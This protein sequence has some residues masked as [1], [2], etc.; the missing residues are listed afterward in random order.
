M[1]DS[2]MLRMECFINN[3]C[4]PCENRKKR[5]LDI[6]SY[7]VNG[8]YKPLFLEKGFEYV[9]LDISEGP[10]VDV[11]P[12][13]MYDWEIIED[14]SFDYIVSGQAFEHIEYPWLTINEIKKK[15]KK[16][17]IIC[18]IAPNGLGEHRYPVDCW[19]F[20]GDGMRALARWCGLEVIETSIGGVPDLY[21]SKKFDSTWN[22]ACLVACKSVDTKNKYKDKQMFPVERR[23]D[24]Y[25]DLKL[26]SEFLGKWKCDEERINQLLIEGVVKKNCSFVY[27]IG[28]E[29]LAEALDK[30]LKRQNIKC[31]CI[32][33]DYISENG[34]SIDNKQILYIITTIDVCRVVARRI[35]NRMQHATVLYLDYL[36]QEEIINQYLKV[37]KNQF[38]ECRNIYIYGAGVNAKEIEDVLNKEGIPFSGFVVSD[39]RIGDKLLKKDVYKISEISNESGIIVS[40][41]DNQD[42]YK[43]LKEKEFKCVFDGLL[44]IKEAFLHMPDRDGL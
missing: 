40:P 25:G 31:R 6:G 15:L 29:F 21:A 34:N 3:Y 1:H 17:G 5:V 27:I 24:I 37:C 13:N 7:N 30:L 2:S 18:I 10:N 43:I 23:Y 20:Y 44:L 33:E 32:N 4:T 12:A 35:Q 42:I 22:D 14:E 36:V 38:K 9:G 8:T 28:E 16:D 11:V 19:R 26:Q 41:Y 39:D